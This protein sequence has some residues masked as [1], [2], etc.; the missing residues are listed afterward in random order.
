MH[1]THLSSEFVGVFQFHRCLLRP[2]LSSSHRSVACTRHGVCLLFSAC[3]GHA[4]PPPP[5]L[6]TV[7]SSLL[8]SPLDTGLLDH[9]PPLVTCIPCFLLELR[10]VCLMSFCIFEPFIFCY[11]SFFFF[12][13]VFGSLGSLHTIYHIYW[14]SELLA[15]VPS[16]NRPASQF[17]ALPPHTF[18]LN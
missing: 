17:D 1:D 18:I 16:I 14:W 9:T 7:P 3:D 15:S 4:F 13:S 11:F 5:R 12:V 8:R 6:S 2:L 10:C